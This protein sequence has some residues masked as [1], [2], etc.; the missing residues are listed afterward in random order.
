MKKNV[1]CRQGGN[2]EIKTSTEIFEEIIAINN[3]IEWDMVTGI[4][5]SHICRR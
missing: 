1:W 2:K 4:S 5:I 3:L